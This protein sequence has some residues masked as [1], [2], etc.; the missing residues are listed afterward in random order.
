MP[1]RLRL[2]PCL[3]LLGLPAP[4]AHAAINSLFASDNLLA[5]CIVP[6][7]SLHRTPGQ[8]MAMLQRLGLNQYVW[9]W[10]QEH[11][12]DLPEEIA[13]AKRAG[14]RIRGVW[15]WVDER[16]DRVGQL[17]AANRLIIDTMKAS[18]LPMEYWLGVH[19][20]VFEGLDQAAAV[21]KGAEFAAYIREQVGPAGTVCLYNH[22]DWFGEPDNEIA[23]IQAAGP[24]RL[25]LIYNLHHAEG[26]TDRFAALLPRMLPYLKAVN[27]NGIN[28]GAKDSDIIP[29]GQGSLERGLI[30]E[31]QQAGY[32]GPLGILGHT[33]GE[34]VEIVLGRNL[35]GLR[36]IAAGR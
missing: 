29:I 24:E 5:W 6:Y 16:N 3:L 23:I 17:G 25:G 1:L 2:L 27:L 4:M 32:R 18:G 15:L 34:D 35:V 30:H 9:D 10:R 31:L 20:N 11:L 22:G 19:P 14:V 26:Q 12:K 13:A 7:D 8:R 33:Q 28:P 21:K 36:E